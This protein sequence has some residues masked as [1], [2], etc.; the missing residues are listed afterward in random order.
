MNFEVMKSVR[1]FPRCTETESGKFIWNDDDPLYGINIPVW[2][3]IEYDVDCGTEQ[4]CDN[5]CDSDYEAIYIN[6]K[7]GKKCYA[8]QVIIIKF[9]FLTF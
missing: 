2:K 4:S 3:Q 8:Y 1:N 9:K 7:L 6:G 5:I